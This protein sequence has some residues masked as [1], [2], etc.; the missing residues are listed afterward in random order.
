MEAVRIPKPYGSRMIRPARP[1]EAAALSDLAL[2]AKAHWG[3]D[4][5]FLKAYRAELTVTAVVMVDRRTRSRNGVS[6][7]LAEK[8]QRPERRDP[9]AP[10]PSSAQV[11]P[12]SSMRGR[13]DHDP[14]RKSP[15]LEPASRGRG[16]GLRSSQLREQPRFCPSSPHRRV[17]EVLPRCILVRIH[18]AS[19]APA[20]LL[21]SSH[22]LA[23]RRRGAFH[24]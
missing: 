19:D 4:N 23:D 21:C 17:R 13:P 18:A 1:E 9:K 10:G 15:L 20:P 14:C 12:R 2:R 24:P 7:I 22:P 3:Y 6:G 11:Q 5:A 16:Q 8:L